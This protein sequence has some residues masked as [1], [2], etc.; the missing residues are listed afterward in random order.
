MV[1][2]AA[3]PTL[4]LSVR[5]VLRAAPERV[6][7]AWTQAEELKRWFAPGPDFSIPISE[8]DLRVG[9]R[10]RL[11]M[12]GPAPAPLSVATGVYEEIT[13]PSRLVFTWRWENAAPEALTTRVTVE[14][15]PHAD[16]TQL[17]ITHEGFTEP[18][19]RDQHAAGWE[20]CVAV[21][22]HVL[23]A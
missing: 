15:R 2:P 3:S 12:Q 16:G 23:A 19:D 1:H 22:E 6:F 9:G 13:P 8:V 20:G 7:R 21:L 5:R 10:Y 4:A 18:S 17:I 11:G 14:F